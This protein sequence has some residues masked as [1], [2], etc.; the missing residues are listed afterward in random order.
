MK[1]YFEVEETD[2]HRIHI[3][4]GKNARAVLIETDMGFIVDV[5]RITDD[6]NIATMSVW[7]EDIDE[8]RDFTDDLS[9]DEQPDSCKAPTTNEILEFKSYWGQTH[10][11]ICE[12]LDYDP[13]TSDDLLMVDYFWVADDD[14]WYPKI[15]S[16][17]TEKDQIIADGL[18]D[19]RF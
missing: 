6:E 9:E 18:R 11:E 1:N 13:L 19:G 8:G 14:R 15:S 17:Y 4:C 2:T 10:K 3:L 5:Y 16:I 12:A 7:N